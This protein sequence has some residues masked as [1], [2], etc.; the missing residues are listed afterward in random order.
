MRGKQASI[1]P[2]INKTATV[3][4][5]TCVENDITESFNVSPDEVYSIKEI[6]KI[7][8]KACDADHLKIEFD[9][10][11]PN[12]QM[13][14]TASNAKM[15]SIFPDIQFTSLFEGIKQTYNQYEA[16]QR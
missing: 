2:D 9:E 16:D 7:A 3:V 6:A 1:V 13:N 14:K 12:G 4:V 11:K 15:K 8:L 5:D 10:S